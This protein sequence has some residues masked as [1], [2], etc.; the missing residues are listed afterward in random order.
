MGVL[1]YDAERDRVV[2]F[3]GRAGWP[4]ADLNDTWEWDGVQWIEV[5]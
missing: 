1:A 4:D 2:L 3:G 5:K